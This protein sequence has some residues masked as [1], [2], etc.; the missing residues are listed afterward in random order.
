MRKIADKQESLLE[1]LNNTEKRVPTGEEHGKKLHDLKD[2]ALVCT[3]CDLRS[4]CKQ[5]VFGEGDPNARLMLVGEGPGGDEDRLG[6][7]FVGRAGQL[8]NQIL[9]AAEIPREEVYI[10]NVVKCRPPGNRNPSQTEVDACS[11]YLVE[12][13]KLIN[14]EIVICL[15]ALATRTIIDKNAAITRVRGQWYERDAARF[16]AT[17][18]P[19]ALLRDP[20]KKKPVWEDFKEVVKYYHLDRG[21]K[22]EQ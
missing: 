22:N 11:S 8:L 13:F 12:Q 4:G 1:A 21:A 7:P 18:H 3:R 2:K 14:P 16:I 20:G 15:G 6:R 10:T 5:V 9:E 19:A 17:F